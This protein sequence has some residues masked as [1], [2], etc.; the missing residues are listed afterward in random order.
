MIVFAIK[1]NRYCYIPGD[2]NAKEHDQEVLNQIRKLYFSETEEQYLKNLEFCLEIISS[3]SANLVQYLM[4]TWLGKNAV[5][6][7]IYCISH[8]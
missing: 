7:D 5:Y 3:I 8:C 2:A 6:C 4:K 1:L